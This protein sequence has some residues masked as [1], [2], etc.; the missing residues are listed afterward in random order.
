M[1]EDQPCHPVSEYGKD[2][3][4]VCR[5]AGE[6]AGQ[7]HMDYIHTRIFSVY[8]PGRSPMVFDFHLH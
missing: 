4:L 6:Q 3:V 1:R 5:Q 7:L 2:K 8:G